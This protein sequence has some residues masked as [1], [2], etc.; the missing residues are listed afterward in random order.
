MS[1]AE[2]CDYLAYY[3]MKAYKTGELCGRTIYYRYWNFINY[4]MLDYV[5]CMERYEVWQ[6][7]HMGECFNVTAMDDYMHYEY[8][9]DRFLD[10]YYV[11]Q[12]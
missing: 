7:A 10:Q 12:H 3:C 4:C 9:D 11:I 1:F 2:D 6:V 8:M 5:N